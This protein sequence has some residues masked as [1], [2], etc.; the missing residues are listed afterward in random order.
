VGYHRGR[1]SRLPPVA[2]TPLGKKT[3]N[4]SATSLVVPAQISVTGEITDEVKLTEQCAVVLFHGKASP[5]I[6][7]KK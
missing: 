3:G 4:M 5:K 2:G 1:K 6:L 7:C